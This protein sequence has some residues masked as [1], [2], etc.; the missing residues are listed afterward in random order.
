V[1]RAEKASYGLK[2]APLLWYLEHSGQI[3]E[4]GAERSKLN[5]PLFL[6]KNEFG[7][8][9]GIIGVHVDDDLITVTEEFFK[10]QVAML[11]EAALLREV[12]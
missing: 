11:E 5:P 9:E 10:L 3:S 8:L 2:D 4:L 7:E 6:F 1:L 12:A